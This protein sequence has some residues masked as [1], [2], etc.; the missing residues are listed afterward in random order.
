LGQIDIV[1]LKL[2]AIAYWHD[3]EKI[4]TLL[5]GSKLSDDCYL[6]NPGDHQGLRLRVHL[7]KAS[8]ALPPKSCRGGRPRRPDPTSEQPPPSGASAESNAAA[9]APTWTPTPSAAYPR[10]SLCTRIQYLASGSDPQ[11]SSEAAKRSVQLLVSLG[12]PLCLVKRAVDCGVELFAV[13]DAV[14]PTGGGG[15]WAGETRREHERQAPPW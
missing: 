15:N 3:H 10:V 6:D 12:S 9:A 2:T 5:A 7:C 13:L 11:K 4:K 8:A 14:Q 1:N